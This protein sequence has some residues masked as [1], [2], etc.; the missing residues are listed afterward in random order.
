MASVEK[1][2]IRSVITFP[3]LADM[4]VPVPVYRSRA[5]RQGRP[6]LKEFAWI[7]IRSAV[8]VLA[9]Q[10]LRP[11]FGFLFPLA[12]AEGSGAPRG[13]PTA[14]SRQALRSLRMLDCVGGAPLAKGARL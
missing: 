3:V 4:T 2:G 7:E 10:F 12:K 13:A 6:S 9:M 5:V 11:R 14:A 1:P 8:V